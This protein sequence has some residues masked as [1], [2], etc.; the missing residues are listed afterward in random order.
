MAKPSPEAYRRIT[1]LLRAI[2]VGEIQLPAETMRALRA[3][4]VLE[5]IRTRAAGAVL[6]DLAKAQAGGPE[7]EQ[8]RASLQRLTA[9][10]PPGD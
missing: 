9:R 7:I 8:A 5:H 10:A 3:V 2:A 6:Q 1:R 4:E